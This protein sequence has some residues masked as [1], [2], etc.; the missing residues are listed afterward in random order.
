MTK[1]TFNSFLSDVRKSHGIEVHQQMKSILVH[2]SY[3]SVISYP[4]QWQIFISCY[5]VGGAMGLWLGLSVFQIVQQLINV[6][7]GIIK[8]VANRFHAE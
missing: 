6:A 2:F 5:Q 8:K 3:I 7:K 1:P 4:S